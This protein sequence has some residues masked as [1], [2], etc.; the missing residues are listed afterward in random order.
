MRIGLAWL[1][2]KRF[3][4]ARLEAEDETDVGLFLVG[5]DGLLRQRVQKRTLDVVKLAGGEVG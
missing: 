3:V 5:A 2:H 4:M 1:I